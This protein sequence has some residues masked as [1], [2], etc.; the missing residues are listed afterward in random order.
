MP[1]CFVKMRQNVVNPGTPRY[2]GLNVHRGFTLSR[3]DDLESLGYILVFLLKG[4]LPWVGL[5]VSGRGSNESRQKKIMKVK[6]NRDF[7][8]TIPG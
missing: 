5:N 4:T 1:V 3:R 7:L 8:P 6:V 2:A